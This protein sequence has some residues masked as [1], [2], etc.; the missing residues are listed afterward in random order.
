MARTG[1]ITSEVQHS[2]LF[3]QEARYTLQLQ[4]RRGVHLV[5]DTLSQLAIVPPSDYKKPLIVRFAM[6]RTQKRVSLSGLADGEAPY[7]CPHLKIFNNGRWSLRA[8][9][10]WTKAA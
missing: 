1:Q 7:V 4:V 9:K 5:D 3:Q 2:I 6:A 10:G 8:R